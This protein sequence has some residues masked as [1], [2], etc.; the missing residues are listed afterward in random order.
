MKHYDVFIPVRLSSSRLPHKAMS[1]IDKKPVIQYLLERL[2]HTKK[3]RKIIVCTTRNRSDDTLVDFLENKKIDVFRGDEQDILVR[4]LDASKQYDTKFAVIVDGDDIYS[5]PV[6]VDLIIGEFEKTNSDY[7]Q[8]TGP[9]VGFTPLGVKTSALRKIC[10]IK[11]SK[12][13]DTGYGRF[14]TDNENLFDIH[15]LKVDVQRNFQTNLRLSLDYKED[16]KLATEIFKQIGNDFH[17]DDILKLLEEQPHLL[18]F[19]KI[20]ESRWND[21]WNTNL[22]DTSVNNDAK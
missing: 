17:L 4:F 19:V 6:L 9:P 22:A 7:I 10:E 12:I 5:D 8:I 3:I 14:F 1:L 18:Q 16:L 2:Q 21:H 15:M 11:K 20:S 13:T